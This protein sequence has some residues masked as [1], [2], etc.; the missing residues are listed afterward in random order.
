MFDLALC[1]FQHICEFAYVFQRFYV[2]RIFCFLIGL[3]LWN[4]VGWLGYV[5]FEG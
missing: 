3:R 1:H 5:E 4:G 2:L